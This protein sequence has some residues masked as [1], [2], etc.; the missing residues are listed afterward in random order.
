ML[1]QERSEEIKQEFSRQ[2]F[3]A[4]RGFLDADE[5]RELRGEIERYLAEVVPGIP[6]RD[7]YF[8]TPGDPDS[9]KQLMRMSQYDAYFGRLLASERFVGLAELLL[10][11][12]VI[13]KNM[14]WFN[15]PAGAG[16]ATP[17]HQDGYYLMLEP[18]E[19]VTMW[20][21]LDDV[22]EDNG[23]MRYVS[24]SHL[25]GLR[26]HE[27]TETLG[28]SQGIPDYGAEDRSREQAVTARPGDLLVHH[29]LM[30]HRADANRS[31]RKR[32]ALGLLYYSARAKED[33]ERLREY[34]HALD[35]E[36]AG[37]VAG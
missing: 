32:R 36:V 37:R 14:Q 23:C 7:V 24:G 28:F 15:K 31:D 3:V 20:L 30:I 10:G 25:G 1:L 6:P 4:I 11:G 27:R 13:N 22:G 9:I 8:E 26:Y 17:P 18:N 33:T 19:A 16:R 34:T 2:G 29:S 35:A 12:P 5:V 21:A